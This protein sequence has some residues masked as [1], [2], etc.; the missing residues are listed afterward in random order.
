MRT[1]RQALFVLPGTERA[2]CFQLSFWPCIVTAWI[3]RLSSSADQGLPT[4]LSAMTYG[5]EWMMRTRK[6]QRALRAPIVSP[7]HRSA[8]H[9]LSRLL[10]FRCFRTTMSLIQGYSSG[11]DDGPVSPT[12]DAFGLASLPVAKKPRVE[13]QKP[14]SVIP[15]SAPDVLSEVRDNFGPF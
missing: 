3:R 13:A 1:F 7:P 12:N 9:K 6:N 10:L 5:A 4:I 11:E 8:F 15:L 14:T 2:T